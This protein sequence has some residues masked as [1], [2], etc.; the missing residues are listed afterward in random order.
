MSKKIAKLEKIVALLQSMIDDLHSEK[1]A[2]DKKAKKK[3]AKAAEAAKG[4]KKASADGASEGDAHGVE[5][6]P[7]VKKARAKKAQAN[8]KP[9]AQRGRKPAAKAAKTAVEATGKPAAKRGRKSNKAAKISTPDI[10][11][12]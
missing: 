3:A 7:Q 4:S 8:G 10:P 1:K 9:D 6:E 5:R 12:L 11:P 2:K